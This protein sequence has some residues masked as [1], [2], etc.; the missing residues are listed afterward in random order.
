VEQPAEPGS[1]IIHPARASLDP[2]QVNPSFDEPRRRPWHPGGSALAPV[3]GTEDLRLHLSGRRWPACA[4]RDSDQPEAHRT[5]SSSRPGRLEGNRWSPGLTLVLRPSPSPVDTMPTAASVRTRRRRPVAVPRPRRCHAP[6]ARVDEIAE[7]RRPR[8][9]LVVNS[10]PRT[11]LGPHRMTFASRAA[12]R[13]REAAM[14]G[15]VSC[16]RAVGLLLVCGGLPEKSLFDLQSRAQAAQGQ[17]NE[18]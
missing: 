2:L 5:R 16:V 17:L 15:L 8:R 6:I 12:P 1:T 7:L 3:L 13:T 18:P 10:P 4:P 9:I 11:N 14:T